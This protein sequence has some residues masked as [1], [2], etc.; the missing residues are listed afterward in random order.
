MGPD[1]LVADRYRKFRSIGM[2]TGAGR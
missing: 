2:F 1:A